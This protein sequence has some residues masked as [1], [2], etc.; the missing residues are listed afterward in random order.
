MHRRLLLA[1]VTAAALAPARP[2]HAASALPPV[3]LPL[4]EGGTLDPRS[5]QGRVA[6]IRFLASW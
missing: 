2:S 5:L 6:V 4:F 3:P 1:G